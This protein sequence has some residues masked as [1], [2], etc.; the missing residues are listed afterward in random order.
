MDIRTVL[1]IF[2]V[3]V[4]C[5]VVLIKFLEKDKDDKDEDDSDE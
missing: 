2:V 3:G 4:I 1:I 5:G